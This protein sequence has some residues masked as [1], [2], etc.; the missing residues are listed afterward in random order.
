MNL[1]RSRQIRRKC[2][3][4]GPEGFPRSKSRYVSFTESGQLGCHS[5]RANDELKFSISYVVEC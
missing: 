4:P 3:G 5:Q 2:S 1:E